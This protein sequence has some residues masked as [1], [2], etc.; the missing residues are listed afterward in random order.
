[1]DVGVQ[2]EREEVVR[3]VARGDPPGAPVVRQADLVQPLALDP[4]RLDPVGHQDP[5]LDLGAGRDDRRP[6]P[7][8]Q[9]PLGRQL[10]AHLAEHLGLQLAEIGQEAAHAARRVVLG[11]PV[12]GHH[13]REVPAAVEGVVRPLEDGPDR[14]ALLAVEGVLD[15]RLLRLVVGG[16][17]PVG[18]PVGRVQ[19][20]PPVGLHDERLAAG[21]GVLGDRVRRRLVVRPLRPR[22]VGHVVAGPLA[23]LLVPPDVGLALRPGPAGRVGRSPVVEQAPVGRPRPPPLGGHPALLRARLAAGG[24]VHAA[25]EAAAVDP[26]AAA[27]R[28]VRLQLGEGRER[29]PVGTPPVDLAQH[30]LGAGL[31]PLVGGVVPG[32][33]LERAVLAAS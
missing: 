26:A 19:P 2:D 29:R 33:R 4:E 3:R 7:V 21:E 17:R 6:C 22:E 11:Q 10:R 12:G 32:Q 23:L 30:R 16:Q 8:R 9:A 1:M 31:A 24:L 5:G 28:A 20:A 13:V 15:R 14:V 25:G 18:E 27:R